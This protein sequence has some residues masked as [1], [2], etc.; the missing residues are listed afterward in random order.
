[1]YI[2]NKLRQLDSFTRYAGFH[3]QQTYI[4]SR[5]FQSGCYVVQ[6]SVYLYH[7]KG[8]VGYEKN[9]PVPAEAGPS[10]SLS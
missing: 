7:I 5:S 2:Y 4:A 10:S 6:I 3:I 9:P 8:G 1:M